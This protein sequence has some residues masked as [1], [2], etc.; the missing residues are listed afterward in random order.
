MGIGRVGGQLERVGRRDLG[1]GRGQ[2]SGQCR[3]PVAVGALPALAWRYQADTA[4]AQ[5]SYD[6]ST[7]AR[8]LERTATINHGNTWYR[9]H[10]AGVGAETSVSITAWTGKAGTYAAWLNGTYLG[11]G[12]GGPEATSASFAIPAGV[13]RAGQENVLAVLVDNTGHDEMFVGSDVE[14]HKNPRGLTVA[15]IVGSAATIDWRIQGAAT[16]DKVR[17]PMNTGGL[18]GERAGWSLPGYPDTGWPGVT[19]PHRPGQAGIGWYRSTVDLALPNGQDVPLGVS[20]E[21]LPDRAL[22]F[23][24][25]WQFGRVGGGPQRVFPIPP[26]ILDPNGRNT[27]AVA[28]W[29]LSGSTA[30]LGSVKLVPLGNS[31]TSL[32]VSKVPA[33]SYDPALF[34]RPV[35]PSSA[36]FVSDLPFL[37]EANGWGPIERDKSVGESQPGD[38]RTLSLRGQTFAKGLGAHSAGDRL[39]LHR[40]DA[41]RRSP[42]LSASTTRP[43]VL[44]R[45]PSPWWRTACLWRRR[46]Y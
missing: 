12:T 29:S 24:N 9:G 17:G 23:V 44:V 22:L 26:G 6:D 39:A 32:T 15:T 14:T 1:D 28:V 21:D 34:P 45:R 16:L 46:A 33:P 13:V 10:F 11:G 43:T 41:V 5:T 18:G 36:V 40:Q 3:R 25:G 20:F 35:A 38:G 30:G 27:F 4:E 19:L 8:A 7:W 42:R 37:A 31:K 2:S